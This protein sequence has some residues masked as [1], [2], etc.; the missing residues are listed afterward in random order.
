[1]P[2]QAYVYSNVKCSLKYCEFHKDFGHNI[3]ESLQEDIEFLILSGYLKEFLADMRQ[4][5]KSLEQVRVN[6]CLKPTP[7]VRHPNDQRKD[8]MFR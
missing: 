1:M 5:R 6:T 3:A 2:T 4:A 8:F 7:N